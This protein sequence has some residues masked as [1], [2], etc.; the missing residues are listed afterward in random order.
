MT[1]VCKIKI[2]QGD[3]VTN[4]KIIIN[5]CVGTLCRH[6]IMLSSNKMQN[7]GNCK[8]FYIHNSL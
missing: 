5:V 1:Y 6:N 7:I 2:F 4:L 8:F 3:V